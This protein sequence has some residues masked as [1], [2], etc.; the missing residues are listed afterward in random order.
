MQRRNKHKHFVDGF[1]S[2]NDTI[3]KSTILLLYD[4]N[5]YIYNSMHS[6]TSSRGND[7]LIVKSFSFIP[8]SLVFVVGKDEYYLTKITWTKESG[9]YNALLVTLHRYFL[10]YK[11]VI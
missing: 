2:A 10:W 9:K 1:F 6:P 3:C 4:T 7:D 8:T 11:C 5:G